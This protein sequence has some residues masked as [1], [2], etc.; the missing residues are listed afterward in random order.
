MKKI[1]WYIVFSALV[2]LFVWKGVPVLVNKWRDY[3]A[4]RTQ[5]LK[6]QVEKSARS[7]TKPATSEV[8]RREQNWQRE[9]NQMQ[10]KTQERYSEYEKP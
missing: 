2:A 4:R 6:A 9:I 8:E 3:E 7:Y 10:D 1:F 5:E